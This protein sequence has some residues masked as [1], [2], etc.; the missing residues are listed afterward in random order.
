[1]NNA[2]GAAKEMGIEENRVGLDS[3]KGTWK[4]VVV[5]TWL[6]LAPVIDRDGWGSAVGH[7]TAPYCTDTPPAAG[8]R[9]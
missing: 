6:C 9:R 1:M 2:R 3:D 4:N 8:N 7:S 5:V